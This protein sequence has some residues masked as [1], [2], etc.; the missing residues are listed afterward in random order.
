MYFGKSETNDFKSRA[1][2]LKK[3]ALEEINLNES[4]YYECTIGKESKYKIDNY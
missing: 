2:V 1:S 3:K 4:K